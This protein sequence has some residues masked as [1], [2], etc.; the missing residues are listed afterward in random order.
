MGQGKLEG[1]YA[2]SEEIPQKSGC[3]KG[4]FSVYPETAK[5]PDKQKS[6]P[7]CSRKPLRIR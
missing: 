5:D 6:F 3:K 7:F 4:N 2:V 1:S